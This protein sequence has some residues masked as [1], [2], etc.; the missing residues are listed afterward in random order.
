MKRVSMA[1]A[2]DHSSGNNNYN[3]HH[4]SNSYPHIFQQVIATILSD[5]WT[6]PELTAIQCDPYAGPFLQSLLRASVVMADE[7]QTGRLVI[8]LLGGNAASGP[9]TVTSDAM[10]RLLTDRHGSHLMEAAFEA[11]PDDVL[12]KML[13]AAFKGRLLNLAQHPSANFAVQAALAAVRRP[14]QLKRMFEDL[15]PHLATLL[16]ARRG[17]VVAVLLAAAGRVGSLES[18]CADALWHSADTGL[19]TSMGVSPLHKLLT[20]DTTTKLGQ[21]GSGIRLSPLGC[22]ALVTVLQYPSAAC[23]KWADA[24]G[25]LTSVEVGTVVRDPGGCRVIE[26]YL[27]GVGGAPKRRRKLLSA[28]KGSWAGAA[29]TVAGCYFVEKCYNVAEV[30][31]REVIT[32]EL[33]AAEDRIGVSSRGSMLLQKCHVDAFKKSGGGGA[34]GEWQKRVNAAGEVKREFAELFGGG[35]DEEVD[36]EEEVVPKK[37]K[38]K[39][40]K[41][42]KS[43]NGA[44]DGEE[45]EEKKKE[46]KAKKKKKDK[47][48]KK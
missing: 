5:D 23:K 44:V 17:G 35:G 3:N 37:K 14:Q 45:G 32:G 6:G 29:S 36:V 24:L 15:R 46:K 34:N 27:E 26:T 18:D 38:M 21:S 31:E 16:R 30:D 22:A 8:H 1:T 42:K 2:V 20:L 19:D 4:T 47:K 13:T 12:Q 11:A 28:L 33:A 43:S 40:S 7:Q 10:Y 39:K 9:D 25:E 41:E 48:D